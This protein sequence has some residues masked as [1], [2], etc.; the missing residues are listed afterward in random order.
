MPKLVRATLT[1][2]FDDILRKE[3]AEFQIQDFG[4]FSDS[5]RDSDAGPGWMEFVNPADYEEYLK[6]KASPE[7]KL[8]PKRQSPKF[9]PGLPKKNPEQ[10]TAIQKAIAQKGGKVDPESGKSP[11]DKGGS[12]RPTGDKEVLG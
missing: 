6:W 10:A 1:G 8:K 3:G 12:P 11:A 5:Q 2:Y 9:T 7:S 4:Q